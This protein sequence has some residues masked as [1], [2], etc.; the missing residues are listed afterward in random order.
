MRSSPFA[1]LDRRWAAAPEA[2]R[3]AFLRSHDIAHRG[4]WGAGVA[5]NSLAAARAAIEG[6]FGIEAA[7]EVSLPGIDR[8]KA[9]ELAKI[10][11]E[12]VCPYSNA[13]RGNISVKWSV[14]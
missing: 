4:L 7:L 10:A 13:T 5:E 11:H 9:E 1:A 2:G 14:V 12:Q 6:G 8:A 3:V